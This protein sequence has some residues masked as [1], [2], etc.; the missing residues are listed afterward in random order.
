MMELNELEF[1]KIS[2]KNTFS[3]PL[4]SIKSFEELAHETNVSSQTLRRFFGKIDKEKGISKT[5]LSLLCIYVGYNDWDNFLKN[6]ETQICVNDTD[7]NY[8]ENMAVFFRNGEKY[9]INY[10]QNTLT[11][12][13]LNDYAKIIYKSKE[14]IEYFYQL[15]HENN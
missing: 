10:H 5:S 2:I 11:A 1:L 9:N 8:I 14:N 13:T 3:K 4:N 7:K 6:Y 12:D 15:Y